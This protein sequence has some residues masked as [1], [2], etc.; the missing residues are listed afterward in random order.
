MKSGNLKMRLLNWL[1]AFA[2]ISFV[3]SLIFTFTGFFGEHFFLFDLTS[4]FRVQY[5]ALQLL[6]LVWL[7]RKQKTILSK[8]FIFWT[9]IAL[10]L[11]GWQVWEY[12]SPQPYAP[13]SQHKPL[14]N[15]LHMNVLVYNNNYQGVQAI[16]RNTN[17]DVV[18]LQE[19]D[20]KWYA[21]LKNTSAYKTYPHQIK[22][23][24]AGNIL[25]SRY[26][27][28]NSRIVSFP[29]DTIGNV[30][31]RNQG[32]YILAKIK[33]GQQMV[34]LINLHPPV[35][36]SPKY[37]RSYQH[38]L[39]LLASEKANLSSSI[40]LF[41]DLNTTP[42]SYYYRQ[43]LAILNLKDAKAHRYMPTWPTYLPIFFIPIDHVL[44]SPDVEIIRQSVGP[45]NG[46]DH[47]P[48]QITLQFS[49]Q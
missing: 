8:L 26:P 3:A 13:Q 18:S 15:I 11:N 6:G 4:H 48:V 28:L 25:L 41:G 33:L 19:I 14:L 36:G 22:H 2:K 35:P 17:A 34:S 32:G 43:Y 9:L 20:S 1:K 16:I 7:F 40:V 27:L 12:A 30:L 24:G 37:A 10:F 21:A 49:N 23:L 5:L 42:W 38:Y 31:Y 46:S 47:L 45:Y 44:V 39:N 29:E